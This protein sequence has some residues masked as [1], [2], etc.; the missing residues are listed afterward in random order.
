M[1]E[2][3]KTQRERLAVKAC[4]CGAHS[5]KDGKFVPFVGYS[6]AGFC[7]SCGKTF[8]PDKKPI[9]KPVQVPKIQPITWISGAAVI[10]T[11]DNY[12]QNNFT[13]WLAKTLGQ[14]ALENTLYYYP[15]GT[16]KNWPGA[17]IFWTLDIN[18]SP[19]RG[20]IMLYD[21]SGHRVKNKNHS[22]HALLKKHDQKPPEC[23]FGEHL[24]SYYPNKPIAIVESAKT[25]II[26]NH[27]LPEY[28]WLS[29][30]GASGLT[31]GKL[32]VL[33]HRKVYLYPDADKVEAWHELA[34]K[35]SNITEINVSQLTAKLG[36][37]R[38]GTDLADLLI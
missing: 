26:A 22:V 31:R 12:D 8:Y 13:R 33:K 11:L 10:K 30:N 20:S 37:N 38:K 2:L 35:Y 21:E 1:L 23:F 9:S 15:I 34:E 19:R 36:E 7:H 25:A 28:I 14:K 4:P 5:N 3:V 29:C 24:L 16:S 18:V 32:T 27:F 17:T 6:D